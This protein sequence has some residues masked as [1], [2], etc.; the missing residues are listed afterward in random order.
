MAGWFTQTVP[1]C[2]N[3]NIWCIIVCVHTRKPYCSSAV[4]GKTNTDDI[5][6]FSIWTN[7]Y[8]I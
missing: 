8:V 6:E 1:Q 3:S 2:F 7:G 4:K 5:F